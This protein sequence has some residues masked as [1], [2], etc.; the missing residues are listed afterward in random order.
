MNPLHGKTALVTGGSRGIGRAVARRLARDGA[1]VAVHYGS[2]EQAAQETVAA[3]VAEGGQAFSLR[4][5]LGT[6]DDA[7]RLW[8][9]FDEHADKLDILVNNAGILNDEPG[10]EHVTRRQ[11]ER[12]FAVNATAPFFVTRLALPRL[13]DGG[14]IV[15]VSTMLTRG[16]AV[17]E[18]ISYAMSKGALDVFTSTL[19][20]QLAARGITV[21]AVAP[22]VVDTDIHQGRIVGEARTYLA[23]QSPMGRLGTPEDVADVVAFLASEDSRWVTGQWVD[24]TGGTLL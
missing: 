19:A 3:I 9:A 16:W 12:I 15:N 17:P 2:N 13:S 18:S 14:R 11:F 10:I 21:N 7:E 20:K 24:V 8:A 1:R 22:G 6:T 5:E 4:T 23:S